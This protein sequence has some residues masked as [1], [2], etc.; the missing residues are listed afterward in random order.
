LSISLVT[1]KISSH[2]LNPCMLMFS[3]FARHLLKS[4]HKLE[5]YIVAFLPHFNN[6]WSNCW[7]CHLYFSK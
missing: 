2:H 7:A 1:A 6:A 5:I 4:G 3:N